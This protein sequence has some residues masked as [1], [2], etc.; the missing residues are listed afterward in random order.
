MSSS[1]PLSMRYFTSSSTPFLQAYW[2]AV[3][4]KDSEGLKE[5]PRL[6]GS[7]M[8]AA[9]H[10][11]PATHVNMGNELIRSQLFIGRVGRRRRSA[12]FVFSGTPALRRTKTR[13]IK[14]RFRYV[15]SNNKRLQETQQ[16]MM[17]NIPGEKLS[18]TH[19][20]VPATFSITSG[21]P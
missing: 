16:E 13:P 17:V 4:S 15:T 8:T 9:A 1:A 7:S 11:L 10:F 12:L 5:L 14:N 19:G 2:S 20:N 3:S 18:C 6:S 21:V